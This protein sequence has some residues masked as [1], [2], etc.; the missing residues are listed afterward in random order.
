MEIIV[1]LSNK[2]NFRMGKLTN[3]LRLN[4]IQFQFEF[5]IDAREYKLLSLEI[6]YVLFPFVIV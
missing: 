2:W 4:N 6:I 3:N 5:W 1:A